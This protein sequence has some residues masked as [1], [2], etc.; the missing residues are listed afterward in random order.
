YASAQA[1]SDDLNRWLRGEP[2]AARPVGPVV[3]LRMW[4]TRK[5][6]LAGLSAALIVASIAGVIGVTWQWR[7]AGSQRNQAR[8]ARDDAVHQEQTARKAEA[9][10]RSARDQA[11]ANEKK[12]VDARAQAEQNAQIAGMQATLALNTIQDLVSQVQ[13]GLH[14]PGLYDLK[15]ALL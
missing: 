2:I 15:V 5:P 10:A 1:L 13:K 7:E 11:V 4:A 8:V 14:G 12:A 3:R 6:A 9:E